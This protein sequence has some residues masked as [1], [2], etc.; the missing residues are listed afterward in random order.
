MCKS[1]LPRRGPFGTPI[2]S[3]S[4]C[5]SRCGITDKNLGPISKDAK[6]KIKLVIETSSYH[7]IMVNQLNS[8]LLFVLLEGM[9]FKTLP[10]KDF[11]TL[12]LMA[13]VSSGLHNGHLKEKA[14][15]A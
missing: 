5:Q 4:S 2:I 10:S 13:L 15:G 7:K 3:Q 9:R 11:R 12:G 8:S 1:G 6:P 14:A